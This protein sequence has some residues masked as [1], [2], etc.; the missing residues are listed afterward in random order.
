MWDSEA[1]SILRIPKQQI[2]SR[3]LLVREIRQEKSESRTRSKLEG[4]FE[5]KGEIERAIEAVIIFDIIIIIVIDLKRYPQRAEGGARAEKLC[6]KGIGLP[7]DARARE[8]RVPVLNELW[9]IFYKLLMCSY[10]KLGASGRALREWAKA[11]LPT[12]LQW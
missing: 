8:E 2:S 11:S 9:H 4:T 10:E 5:E 1:L 3:A 7:F 6:T 12:A